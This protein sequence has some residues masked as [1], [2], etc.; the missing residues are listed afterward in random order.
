MCVTK[1]SAMQHF[2]F[3]YSE[4]HMYCHLFIKFYLVILKSQIKQYKILPLNSYVLY[5]I[6]VIVFCFKTQLYVLHNT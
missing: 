3:M 2:F 5:T 4:R 1:I 6:C